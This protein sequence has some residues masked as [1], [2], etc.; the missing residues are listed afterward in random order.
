MLKEFREFIQR[1]NVM[2]LAVGVIIGGAFGKIVSSIVDDMLMPVISL[3]TGKVDFSNKFIPLANQTATSL[4]EAR[5][6]G[7]V[8]A[9][10]VFVNNVIVFLITAFAV[11]LMVKAVNKLRR[12]EPP[13][14]EEPAAPA[15][16]VVLL[17]EIR[18][19]LKA[20]G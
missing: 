13:A 14:P 10:G 12:E 15:E 7:A 20:R 17:T 18:D 8:L 19:L 4:E 11:F 1:G 9:W 16:D 2:D 6:E 3:L 5:K